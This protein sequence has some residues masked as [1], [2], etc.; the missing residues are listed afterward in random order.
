MWK[1][2]SRSPQDL[3]PVDATVK[4]TDP[5]HFRPPD[6]SLS[7]TFWTNLREQTGRSHLSWA[8]LGVCCWQSHLCRRLSLE[9]ADNPVGTLLLHFCPWDQVE[10]GIL[11]SHHDLP[12]LSA[13][14]DS[15]FPRVFPKCVQAMVYTPPF[16]IQSTVSTN[17]LL[18]HFVFHRPGGCEAG[19]PDLM[20]TGPPTSSSIPLVSFPSC[21]GLMPPSLKSILADTRVHISHSASVFCRKYS[22]ESY[23]WAFTS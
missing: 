1:Q 19:R 18:S 20:G 6:Q 11:G 13:L 5:G 2:Q 12:A 4:P 7:W 15:L 17:T 23:W 22:V 3:K 8:V 21:Q 14:W 9:P 10:S 16:G